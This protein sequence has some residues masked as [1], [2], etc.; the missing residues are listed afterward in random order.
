[1]LTKQ[2]VK[3]LRILYSLLGLG[4]VAVLLGASPVVISISAIPGA[5]YFVYALYSYISE[6]VA[7]IRSLTE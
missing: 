6:Q 2:D 4:C 7:F 3:H 1:M 5:S